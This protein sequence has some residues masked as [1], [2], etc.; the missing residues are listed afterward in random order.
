[1]AG[2]GTERGGRS[3]MRDPGR[4]SR[5]L[6]STRLSSG[7]VHE[8]GRRGAGIRLGAVVQSPWERNPSRKTHSHHICRK[9]PSAQF[10]GPSSDG[11]E[12]ICASLETKADE[13][14]SFE[15]D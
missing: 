6:W 13:H 3:Q 5:V 9:E 14:K 10:S 15:R 8:K 1:M 12:V 7:S 11:P 2:T 4:P